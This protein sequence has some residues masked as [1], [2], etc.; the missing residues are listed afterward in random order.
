MLEIE[1]KAYCEKHDEIIKKIISLGG[2][3]KKESVE[4]DIY[5]KH[6]SRD[7][8]ETDEALRI[9]TEDDSKITLT[10]KGPKIG[11]ETKTRIESEVKVDDFTSMKEI[12]TRL[13]FSIVEE[14]NKKRRYYSLG[15]I[16]ICLDNVSGLG[17]F[18]EL[19]KKGN[20]IESGEKELFVLADKIGLSKFERKSYLEL[21][22]EK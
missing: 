19:E 4:R 2:I 14:V 10:Y 13:G 18:V 8:A 16:D 22:L 1:I 12:L 20:D 5:F 6:P 9:R 7:F 3:F 11:T 21:I 17:D 15:E